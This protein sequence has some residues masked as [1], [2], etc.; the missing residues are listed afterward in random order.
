MT[1]AKVSFQEFFS[2]P[3][4]ARDHNPQVPFFG[5]RGRSKYTVRATGHRGGS[6]PSQWIPVSLYQHYDL[7]IVSNSLKEADQMHLL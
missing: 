3:L 5:D 1:L 2:L 7:P 6:Q 4:L